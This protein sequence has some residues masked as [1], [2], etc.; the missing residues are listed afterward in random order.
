MTASG[1]RPQAL[2]SGL[3]VPRDQMSGFL[4][5][6]SNVLPMSYAVEAMQQVT[7]YA[8]VTATLRRDF[9]IIAGCVLVALAA[10]AA[11]LRRRTP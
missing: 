4:H 1:K 5:A 2:L 6:L 8:E 3:I 9:L 11:T 7:R 10:G